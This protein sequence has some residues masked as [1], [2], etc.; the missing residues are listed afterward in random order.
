MTRTELSRTR[1]SPLEEISV[2]VVTG[3]L[4]F[5]PGSTSSVGQTH[6]LRPSGSS[7]LLYTGDGGSGFLGQEWDSPGQ[8][9]DTPEQ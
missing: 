5:G 1:I 3:D 8:E 2:P 6:V 7:S 4:R 9:L